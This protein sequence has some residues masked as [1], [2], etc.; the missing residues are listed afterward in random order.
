[1]EIEMRE[2]RVEV[3]KYIANDGEIF[4]SP[5]NCRIHELLLDG[6]LIECPVCH[7]EGKYD[8]FGD[9]RQFNTCHNCDGKKYIV[10]HATRL[11]N[12]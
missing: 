11:K 4:D 3:K 5:E 7:G 6:T 10:N 9:G 2:I 1:M 8:M 12:D